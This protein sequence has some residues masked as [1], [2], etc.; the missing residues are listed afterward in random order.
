[1]RATN[2]YVTTEYSFAE[3]RLFNYDSV[4]SGSNLLTLQRKVRLPLSIYRYILITSHHRRAQYS[5]SPP[6]ELQMSSDVILNAL[7]KMPSQ[8]LTSRLWRPNI[9]VTNSCGR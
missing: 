6:L 9:N 7:L 1:V 3:Y 2:V 5:N 4:K 8:T